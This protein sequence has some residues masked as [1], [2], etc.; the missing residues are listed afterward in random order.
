MSDNIS[1]VETSVIE[2]KV[3]KILRQTDYTDEL[4]R[5]KLKENNYDEIATI[6]AYLGIG[7]KS[8][9]QVVTSI[10]QEIFKQIRYRLDSNM[11]DYHKRVEKGEAKNML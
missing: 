9:P 7:E 3:Q 8:K 2:D 6:K 5:E 4:A 1:L 10:N 11:R